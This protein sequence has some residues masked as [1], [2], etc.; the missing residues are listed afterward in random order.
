MKRR[1]WTFFAF[2]LVAATLCF[3]DVSTA[4]DFSY[5]V[6]N[7]SFEETNDVGGAANWHD[8]SKTFAVV[9][10][11]ARS[12]NASLKWTGNA[13]DSELCMQ[14]VDDVEP[15]DIVEF[16]VWIKTR[17]LTGGY[18]SIG[19]EW[20]RPGGGWYGGEFV[21]G[22]DGTT[23]DWIKISGTARV[24]E[25]AANPHVTVYVSESGSGTAWF[26]DVEIKRFNLPLFTAMTTD[27]YRAQST[28]GSVDVYVGYTRTVKGVDFRELKPE[29]SIVG[30]N[31]A[32]TKAELVEAADDYYRFSFDSSALNVGK[33]TLTASMADPN[34][35]K[36]ETIST[37]FSKL[38]KFPD[39]VSYIDENLRLIHNGEP[40]FP[41]GL[42][43]T[44]ATS[45]EIDLIRDSAFNC[46][47]PYEPFGRKTVDALYDAG[48]Y[49]IYSVKENYPT[50]NSATMEEANERVEK[51]VDAVR[52]CPG[53]IAW[54][55][56]DEL[57][58]TMFDDLKARCEQME[59]LDPSRPTWS[60]LYQVD[61]LRSYLPTFDVVGSDPYPIPKREPVMAAEWTQDTVNAVFGKRAVWQVPQIFNQASYKKTPEE[62]KEY[63]A[64][65][66][67]EMRC[68]AWA[69]IASGANGLI[70]F[71]L[72]DLFNMDKT[73]E[74][75]GTALVRD[76]FEER[77]ADV[78]RMAQEIRDQF[79]ILLSVDETLD[80]SPASSD[81]LSYRLYGAD[82]GTWLL[83]VNTSQEPRRAEFAVPDGAEVVE[84]RLGAPATQDGTKICVDLGAM[85]PRL[86]L[87]RRGR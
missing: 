28:G 49:T 29:L 64:P 60:V 18:A 68:M 25:D 42:Y 40:F 30:E 3:I 19:L 80:V 74:E 31:G 82:E 23:D 59:K 32:K 58:L 11:E 57:P 36:L 78:K 24:P 4:D 1:F 86:I 54:Y 46:V 85:E 55:I 41:L 17:E 75:G 56:N 7:P 12:G 5:R 2:V 10:G 33:Y 44:V 76:P 84:T 66:F 16:S 45:R 26:D 47:M 61:E 15:G 63:R 9:R 6:A 79:P 87:I 43:L 22:V 21:Q 35:G 37:P 8:A 69:C 67:E 50:L 38:D 81:G 20:G 48:L 39:R 72:F 13:S 34:T 65:T 14:T 73:I 70:F 71:S 27:R 83:V 52:D 53:V 62:K 77:W 51:T